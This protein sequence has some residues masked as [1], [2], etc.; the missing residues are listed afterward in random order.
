MPANGDYYVDSG[1]KSKPEQIH[2][3]TPEDIQ[4][5]RQIALRTVGRINAIVHA[6]AAETE[7]PVRDILG[8]TRVTRA[9][10]ARQMVMYIARREGFSLSA[11]GRVLNRD[12]SSVAH[13]VKMEKARRGE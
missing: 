4:R 12:H 7:V 9:T 5:C 11:I 13:G 6:V 1:A 8:Q 10:H 3:M 2:N